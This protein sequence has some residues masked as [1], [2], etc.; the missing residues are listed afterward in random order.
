[1]TAIPFALA[2]VAAV[3][4]YPRVI[5]RLKKAGIVGKDVNKPDRPEV[6]EMGGLV[7]VATFSLGLLAT[8]GL[9]SFGGGIPG[10][11]RE[12]LLA[13]LA[14]VLIVAMIGVFD[15]LIHVRKPLKMIAPV[16]A[17]LPLVAVKAGITQIKLPYFDWIDVGWLYPLVFVPIGMTGAAN[18]ANILGGFNGL[19]AGLGLIATSALAVITFTT[20]EVTPFLVL[21]CLAGPLVVTLFFNWYPAKVFIGD[22]GTLSI[23]A[24]LCAASVLG[25]C[26]TAGVLV[27]IPYGIDFFIKARNRLPSLGWWGEVRDGKLHCPAEGPVGLCQLVMKLHGGVSEVGLVLTLLTLEA[28]FAAVAVAIYAR[29]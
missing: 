25:N 5:R 21:L 19:E 24:V 15:D 20:G 8:I 16:V 3:L 28:L 13:T 26:E 17:A 18:A 6:A 1:M 29:F 9:H 14:S 4:L 27:M 2:F 7:I 23:G 11:N 22:V 12:M 10:V